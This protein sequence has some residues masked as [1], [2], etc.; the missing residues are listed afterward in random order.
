MRAEN[1]FTRDYWLGDV[2]PRPLAL[3]R[4]LFGS[5]FLVDLLHRLP[6]I[7]FFFSDEGYAPREAL[8]TLA[9][10]WSLFWLVGSPGAVLVLYWAGIVA[11]AALTLGFR[12][13]LASM[14]TFAFI[15][16][17][18]LRNPLISIGADRM[19]AVMSFWLIL[20]DAGGAF[21]LDRRMGRRSGPTVP[22]AGL[23]FLQWQVALVYLAAA[24]AKRKSWGDGL[25]L[26]RL[27]QV[28][29]CTRPLGQA[30]TR[31][32]TLSIALNWLVLA[33]ELGVPLLLIPLSALAPKW[34]RAA[35]VAG[36]FILF[37]GIFL[38]M[39]VGAFPELMVAAL[40]LFLLPEWLDRIGAVDRTPIAA[41]L[42]TSLRR[43]LAILGIG[44][45]QLGLV[46]WSLAS[47]SL[48]WPEGR[49]IKSE[50][51]QL[52][53][54]QAWTMFAKQS[55]PYD[56]WWTGSGVLENGGRSEV[57]AALVPEMITTAPDFDWQ[58]FRRQLMAPANRPERIL[59]GGYV[60]RTFNRGAPVPMRVF[61]LT[62]H[63]QRVHD[64]GVPAEEPIRRVYHLHCSGDLEEEPAG[65]QPGGADSAG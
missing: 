33:A 45:L 21:S 32:P 5:V 59:F 25:G 18:H 2:D 64:P 12:T 38:T 28:H 49:L 48:R 30:L 50:I 55:L 27:M 31:W 53:L 29:D 23:R 63:G 26:Y 24:L 35:G 54:D 14:A 13:R 52:D 56:A 62:L 1:P 47:L 39:R 4:I 36:G 17:L 6:D 11:V 19:M 9:R 34:A 46:A 43:R 3:F 51:Q 10:G 58:N 20:A 61:E 40:A 44:G 60:C 16:S 8:P 65:S 37:T 7:R 57:L 22:A 15:A 41:P 42:P